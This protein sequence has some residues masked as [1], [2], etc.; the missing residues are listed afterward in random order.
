MKRK[1]FVITAGLMVLISNPVSTQAG[2]ENIRF[3]GVAELGEIEVAPGVIV[4]GAF[5]TPTTIARVE[6]LLSSIITGLVPAV[7]KARA[8]CTLLLYTPSFRQIRI[9]LEVS[10]PKIAR[11]RLLRERTLRPAF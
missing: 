10:P 11:L 6:G 7:Q 3:E 5:P 4:L 9:V 8:Q 2:C 1:L